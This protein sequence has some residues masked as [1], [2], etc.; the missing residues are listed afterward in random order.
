MIKPP[1]ANYNRAELERLV[2]EGFER[3]EAE[4]SRPSNLEAVAFFQ[5]TRSFMS[6]EDFQVLVSASEYLRRTADQYASSVAGPSKEEAGAVSITPF[7]ALSL[8]GDADK[9]VAERK[10]VS[11]MFFNESRADLITRLAKAVEIWHFPNSDKGDVFVKSTSGATFRYEPTLTHKA[12]P[13]DTHMSFVNA[14]GEALRSYTK[15]GMDDEWKTLTVRFRNKPDSLDI[16][17][18]TL[19]K[20]EAEE[21]PKLMDAKKFDE[22]SGKLFIAAASHAE[23]DEVDFVGSDPD[24]WYS[25]HGPYAAFEAASE[26]FDNCD[27]KYADATTQGENE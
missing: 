15:T 9:Y 19:S 3:I 20:D 5:P 8:L 4:A 26:Y 1:F 11:V 23:N 6:M 10:S 24:G 25:T 18:V 14:I 2:L 17:G 16:C 22:L 12:Q 21:K 13:E 27:F 7:K